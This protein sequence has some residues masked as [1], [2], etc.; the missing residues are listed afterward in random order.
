MS[1]FCHCFRVIKYTSAI[2][3]LLDI[4]FDHV[5]SV[6]N[7]FLQTAVLARGFCLSVR[8]S[9]H[10]S[11]TF[12]CFVQMNEDTIVRFSVSRGTITLVSRKVKRG[13]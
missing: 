1:S 6:F 9:V 8:P 11:V 5:R 13:R 4:L 2:T 10:S 3:A 7:S 12:R